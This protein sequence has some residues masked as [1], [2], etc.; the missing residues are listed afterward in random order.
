MR[1]SLK[2]G[3]FG[4]VIAGLIGG[5]VAWAALDKTV[6]LIVD[7]ETST[8]STY[9][10]TVGDILADAEISVGE[11]DTLAPPADA[12]VGDGGEVVLNRG[13]LLT[14][15]VDGV[16]RQIWVT[17]RSVADAL[18]Q[19]G[20]RQNDLFV[21]ASRSTRVPLDGLAVQLRTPKDITIAVDGKTLDVTTTAPTVEDLLAEQYI[22]LAPT[23]TT[24]LFLTQ[25]LLSH[26]T[27]TVTRIRF[28]EVQATQP[29]PHGRV[30]RSDD[31]IFEG[32]SEVVQAGVDGSQVVTFK[33]TKTNGKE[34]AREEIAR[35][36]TQAPVEEI[37]AVGT[38][39]RPAPAPAPQPQPQPQTRSSGGGNTGANPPPSSGGLNWDA[40]AGCESG[41]NWSINTGNG[42]YGGLQFD[43]STWD[44]SGGQA[45]A[46]YPHQATREQ[47][48]AVGENLYASRGDSPWPT[49]GYLLHT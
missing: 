33:V 47:Q 28:A 13:R 5:S 42:Y 45:Y 19:L 3:L 35:E 15:T 20:F 27:V 7:G 11:H 39:E 18:D 37:V 4:L 1:R 2:L 34:S 16:E 46:P 22:T 12:T 14:L 30:A 48:I 21:S 17:A 36:V 9:A 31:S 29:V 24:S 43:K 25:P 49:C 8:V 40:L 38:R 10:A 26:M 6:T 41:G 44:A 23:D 32:E